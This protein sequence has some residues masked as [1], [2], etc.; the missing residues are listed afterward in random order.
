MKTILKEIKDGSFE[1][2]WSK[3]KESNFKLLNDYRGKDKQS[4]IEAIT[5]RLLELL[6]DNN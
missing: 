6:K 3:E 4:E 5:K 2:E 1:R